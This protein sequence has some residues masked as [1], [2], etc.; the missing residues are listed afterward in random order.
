MVNS[1]K[2]QLWTLHKGRLWT[3]FKATRRLSIA[4]MW[5][6]YFEGEGIPAR[7]LPDPIKAA[8]GEAITY[9][10]LVTSD[11]EHLIEEVLKRI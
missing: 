2:N 10:V 3:E 6:D 8:E 4:Q 9:R 5:K 7:I 11:K 1:E